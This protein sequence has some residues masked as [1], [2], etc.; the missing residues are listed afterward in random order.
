MAHAASGRQDNS[1]ALAR[2]AAELQFEDLPG[3]VVEAIKMSV[4][5]TLGSGLFGS[6]TPWGKIIRDFARAQPGNVPLWGAGSASSFSH[7]AALANATMAHGFELDDLHPG[8]RSHPGAVMTPLALAMLPSLGAL[9]GKQMITALAAGYEVQGRV[10]LAQGVSSFNRGWHPT[11]TAGAAGAAAAAAR[12]RKLNIEQTQHAIG[13]AASMPAGLMAAQFGAMVKRLYVGHATWA[14]MVG[15]D[16]AAAGFTGVHDVFD[17]EYGGYLAAISDEAR[18]ELL[19]AD[20]GKRF[21]AANI[22]VK[23]WPCVGTNQS[24]L[25]ALAGVL[26]DHAFTAAD[27]DR[28]DVRT[29]EYQK[30]HSGWDYKPTSVMAAQMSMQYCVAALIIEG[31]LFVD[32]FTPEKIVAPAAIELARRVK[33]VAD[34]T[35]DKT[36]GFERYT[37][38]RIH[39]KDGR[40][41]EGSRAVAHGSPKDPADWDEVSAKFASLASRVLP[42]DRV[43]RLIDLVA[44]LETSPD[45]SGLTAAMQFES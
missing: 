1:Q 41:L 21:E 6:T 4:L 34:G 39:L 2:Y 5:D 16:L 37:E 45:V 23:F 18:P 30:L 12:L 17:A 8:S 29:T 42:A 31:R 11:G 20:L 13:I 26:R 28:I 14:G 7:Y 15:A 25:D 22:G 43:R 44:D 24:L 9:P 32:E 38:I 40:V 35:L 36:P 10:G 19:I 3:K 27:V 33:I